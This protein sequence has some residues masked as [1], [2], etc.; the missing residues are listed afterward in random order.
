MSIEGRIRELSNKHRELDQQIQD[1][2][3]H[4]SS[5]PLELQELKRR[6]LRLKEEISSLQP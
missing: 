5:D 2:Q 6:K 4:A 3:K 1:V